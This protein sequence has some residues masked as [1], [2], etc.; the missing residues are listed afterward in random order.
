MVVNF[1]HRGSVTEAPENTVSAVEKALAHGAKAIE[2]DV[3][4]TKDDHLVIVH[5]HHLRRFDKQIKGNVRDYTLKEIKQFNIGAYFSKEFAQEKLATLDE[6]LTIIPKE[7]CLNI[8]IKNAPIVYE[9]ISEILLTTLQKY[10]RTENVLISSFNHDT[11]QY[12][13]TEAPHIPLGLLFERRAIRLL[14]AVKRSGLQVY[15]IHPNKS[16]VNKRFIKKCH[17]AGY[18]VYPYTVNDVATYERFKKWGID[19]VFSDNPE[20]FSAT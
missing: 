10:E 17:E 4:I 3:R 16:H 5:D 15:S 1:A 20:I 19:G 9:H 11:L 6:M 13:Q 2:M 12:F 7:V 8:E 14:K 18:K